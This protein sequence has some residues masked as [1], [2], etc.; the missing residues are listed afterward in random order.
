MKIARFAQTSFCGRSYRLLSGVSSKLKC[1]RTFGESQNELIPRW[2]PHH[3]I[4]PVNL[5]NTAG[6]RIVC[7]V[8][9]GHG[10]EIGAVQ[11]F[12]MLSSLLEV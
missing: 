10:A 6:A 12:Y 3:G 5:R 11:W 8:W 4:D 7:A 1:T 2:P 9:E